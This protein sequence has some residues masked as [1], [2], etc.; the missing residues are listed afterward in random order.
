LI[1]VTMDTTTVAR[2]RITCV[3]E[4]WVYG[5]CDLGV[6]IRAET[7]I[8]FYNSNIFQINKRINELFFKNFL[9]K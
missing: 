3:L 5:S 9:N 2:E 4:W 6:W 8:K 7:N 1:G